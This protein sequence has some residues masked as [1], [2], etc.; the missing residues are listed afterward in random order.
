M[1]ST[2]FEDRTT[3]VFYK[4]QLM[5]DFSSRELQNHLHSSQHRQFIL[6]LVFIGESAPLSINTLG[7]VESFVEKNLLLDLS[8]VKTGRSGDLSG[9]KRCLLSF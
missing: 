1:K 4:I 7:T 5:R 8:G 3:D 2:K 6:H 9:A